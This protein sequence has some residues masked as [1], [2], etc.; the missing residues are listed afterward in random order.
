MVVCMAS[1][2][3]PGAADRWVSHPGLRSMMRVEPT[4]ASM[5][6][7]RSPQDPHRSRTALR[8]GHRRAFDTRKET[9]LPA[10]SD[11]P[12]DLRQLLHR[13]RQDGDVVEISARVSRDLE[14]AE[15]HRRVIAA[16]VAASETCFLHEIREI[17]IFCNFDYTF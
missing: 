3:G 14:V 4:P 16:H 15:I 7:V 2:S 9:P 1:V 12:R 13:F 6:S 5:G 17:P 8:A 11:A 10:P